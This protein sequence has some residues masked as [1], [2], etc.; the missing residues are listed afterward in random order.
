MAHYEKLLIVQ[1]LALYQDNYQEVASALGL[2]LRT[3]R[4]R[5]KKYQIT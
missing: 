1:M 4:Y 5:L 3:L 2:S